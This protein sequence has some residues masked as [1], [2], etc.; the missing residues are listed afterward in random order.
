MMD[1][2][3]VAPSLAVRRGMWEFY[4]WRAAHFSGT[5]EKLSGYEHERYDGTDAADPA[6]EL[7]M[8][9][10]K[11]MEGGKYEE[12]RHVDDKNVRDKVARVRVPYTARNSRGSGKVAR[13]I[14]LAALLT[15]KSLADKYG[16]SKHDLG[17]L[18]ILKMS[19]VNEAVVVANAMMVDRGYPPNIE[20]GGAMRMSKSQAVSELRYLASQIPQRPGRMSCSVVMPAAKMF[21]AYPNEICK[22]VE[23]YDQWEV[24]GPLSYASSVCDYW[25]LVAHYGIDEA[26]GLAEDAIAVL[27][28]YCHNYGD[29]TYMRCSVEPH[30]GCPEVP[31]ETEGMESTLDD[32]WVKHAHRMASITYK[33]SHVAYTYTSEE[34]LSFVNKHVRSKGGAYKIH[35]KELRKFPMRWYRGE[36]W[37]FDSLFA[38]EVKPATPCRPPVEGETVR[39]I[40]KDDTRPGEVIISPECIISERSE[41][42]W[43][44]AC[45]DIFFQRGM[46]GAPYVAESDGSVVGIHDGLF[47]VCDKG[48]LLPFRHRAAVSIE[49]SGLLYNLPGVA[50]MSGT[51]LDN[52]KKSKVGKSRMDRLFSSVRN[53]GDATLIHAYGK[54]SRMGSG[55][56]GEKLLP[57][58]SAKLISLAD[59][60]TAP[61][62]DYRSA[63]QGETVVMLGMTDDG[64]FISPETVVESV[65]DDGRGMIILPE[66]IISEAKKMRG[67]YVVAVSD[68]RVVAVTTT[69]PLFECGVQIAI[70][71]RMFENVEEPDTPDMVKSLSISSGQVTNSSKDGSGVYSSVDGLSVTEIRERLLQ[72]FPYLSAG[73]YNLEMLAEAFTSPGLGYYELQP[74]RRFNGGLEYLARMGD[75]VLKMSIHQDM[76]EKDVPNNMAT[77]IASNIQTNSVQAE[78]AISLGIP[79]WIRRKRLEILSKHSLANCLEALSYIVYY[80][81]RGEIFKKFLHDI[82]MLKVVYVGINI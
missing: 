57:G 74:D 43:A 39:M 45:Q 75:A 26:T 81:E 53:D 9:E 21:T 42:A 47:T 5:G 46:S 72:K 77:I 36:L 67:T 23:E 64:M 31:H 44:V 11:A 68:G 73:S 48:R 16:F 55:N 10:M 15:D 60:L 24:N 50:N 34:G 8:G 14:K 71:A 22:G 32:K 62:I 6:R 38:K 82:G 20:A 65:H 2:S 41:N 76:R 51:I 40:L 29:P 25:S 3:E 7:T 28:I 63:N 70:E 33:G 27:G 80:Y 54:T 35:G 61:K 30:L 49:T 58:L 18:N 69:E 4:G 19:D 52:V 1:D 79:E 78:M 13:V 66:S 12:N 59:S 17:Q 37:C 56:F